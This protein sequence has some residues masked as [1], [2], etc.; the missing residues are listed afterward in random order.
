MGDMGEL[1]RSGWVSW[2]RTAKA[3]G[4][5]VGQDAGVKW[6]KNDGGQQLAGTVQVEVWA[7]VPMVVV[8]AVAAA[9]TA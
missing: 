7:V 5:L 6:G 3:T 9:V 2:M 4:K 1:L 8:V